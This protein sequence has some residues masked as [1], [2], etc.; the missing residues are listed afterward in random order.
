MTR[1]KVAPPTATVEL[2]QQELV[3]IVNALNEVCNGF[4]ITEFSTRIGADRQA[5]ERLLAAVRDVAKG[6]VEK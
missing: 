2:S 4:E 3:I 6:V 1:V 5:A